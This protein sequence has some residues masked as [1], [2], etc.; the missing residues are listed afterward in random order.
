M[1]ESSNGYPNLAKK[2]MSISERDIIIITMNLLYGTNPTPDVSTD[3]FLFLSV[4]PC[5][6]VKPE[7]GGTGDH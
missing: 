2:I 6:W 7:G 5:P 1:Q 3:H 4:Y